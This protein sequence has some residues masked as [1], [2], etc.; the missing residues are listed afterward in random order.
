MLSVN[1]LILHYP[2]PLRGFRSFILREYL[3]CKILQIIFSDIQYAEKLC[4]LGG[5]SLRLV[6]GNNRFSED[7][8]FDQKGLHEKEFEYIAGHVQ[9]KLQLEGY[10]VEMKHVAAGAYHCYIQF[11]GLLFKEGLSG[12]REQKILIQLDAEAQHVEFKPDRVILNKFDVFTELP[13][14]PLPLLL[15]QK[16]YALINR[17]R[18]KG[19]DFFDIVFL[20]SRVTKPD[21]GYLQQ[22]LGIDNA[23]KL[24]DKVLET[25][26]RI[27][28]K[29]MADDV[30]PFLFYPGDANK[31]LLFEQ[32]IRQ[33]NLNG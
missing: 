23:D 2:E 27:S 3:Q 6:H 7:I 15:A 25:C 19:R 12:Y 1:E 5:T 8:D 4:F 13:V 18:S 28:M 14:T 29:E 22:K 21:Y 11:P 20:L 31:V 26:S 30:A 33:V 32:Y 10:E 24:K 9:R 17:K 16:F